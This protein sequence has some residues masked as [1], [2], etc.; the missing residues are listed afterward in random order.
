[1]SKILVVYSSHTGNTRRLAE[2]VAEGAREVSGTEV[3][4]KSASETDFIELADFDG[5]IAGSPVYFGSMA[6]ELKALFDRSVRIRGQLADKV[7]AAF[8]TSGHATGGKETTLLSILHAMLIH[9]MII[10]GDP[11]S[12]GGHYGVGIVGTDVD[13]EHGSALALG[14]RVAE[15]VN[16][17]N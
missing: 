1:M 9:Q 12:S 7:G 13:R 11:I 10:V 8:A 14:R 6:S 3:V 4:V 15:V 2:K 16:R 17:L 5:L